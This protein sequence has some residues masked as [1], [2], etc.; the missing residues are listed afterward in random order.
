MSSESRRAGVFRRRVEWDRVGWNFCKVLAEIYVYVKY[1]V[2]LV[3]LGLLIVVIW[4]SERMEV[5][6]DR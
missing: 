3:N 4:F 6:Y 1:I 2:N 5:S